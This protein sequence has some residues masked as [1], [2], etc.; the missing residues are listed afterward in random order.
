MAYRI[1]QSYWGE[2]VTQSP[3]QLGELTDELKNQL[4]KT[5]VSIADKLADLD[6]LV[7]RIQCDVDLLES[8]Q[9]RQCIDKLT[10]GVKYMSAACSKEMVNFTN[11]VI[12]K[13]VQIIGEPPC[14]FAAVG[15]GSLAKGET[16]PYSDLEFLFLIEDTTGLRYFERLALTIYFCIGNLQE[17]KLK[18]MNIKE[19]KNDWFADVST[20]G[21]KIDGLQPQA[22]N[23]PTGNGTAEQKNK[24][25]KTVDEMVEIYTQVF[26]NPDPEEAKRGDLSAMLSSTVLLYGDHDLYDDFVRRIHSIAPSEARQEASKAMLKNDMKRYDYLPDETMMQIK[27][28]KKD[29]YRFPSILVFDLKISHGIVHPTSWE[30]LETLKDRGFVSSFAYHSLMTLLSISI[31]SRLSAYAYH[32]SQNDGMSVLQQTDGGASSNH[33]W[34]FPRALLLYYFVYCIPIKFQWRGLEALTEPD[35]RVM[36]FSYI[37]TLHHSGDYTAVLECMENLERVSELSSLSQYHL[38]RIDSLIKTGR[39]AEAGK[40]IDETLGHVA[41]SEKATLV[42]LHQFRGILFEEENK[43]KAALECQKRALAL[44]LQIHNPGCDLAHIDSDLY[45]VRDSLPSGDESSL[46]ESHQADHSQGQLTSTAGLS[47]LDIAASYSD[48]GSIY[49]LMGEFSQALHYHQKSLVIQLDIAGPSSSDAATSY[50]NIAIIHQQK[51]D[52]QSAMDLYQKSLSTLLKVYGDT[53][54]PRISAL[55]NNIAGIYKSHGHY[56][57][58]LS[59]YQRSLNIRRIAYG[60][61]PHS[62]I[63]AS[64]NN[65]TDVYESQ[66]DYKSALEWNKKCLSMQIEIYGDSPHPAVAGAYGNIAN[67]YQSQGDHRAAMEY[68]QRGLTLLHKIH[69][70]SPNPQVASLYSNIANIH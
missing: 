11:A 64:Y 5:R 40:L 49:R 1:Q 27:D 46:E 53:P 12:A 4:K 23:I 16:T 43:Y 55:Y 39:H 50:N 45:P 21:F 32:S 3:E 20:S 42:A 48:I 9:S 8:D 35:S 36:K 52:Y 62:S 47:H 7:G 58:A 24:F 6:S 38:I 70:D 29:F 63:A 17:T 44:R 37:G 22:G 60:N 65:I 61:G 2:G 31:Y 51:G 56:S 57:L 68:S 18:Y 13:S 14:S 34:S 19:L 25:I 10:E 30:V 41:E 15:I 69:G 59:F 28:L 54:H 66:A 33:L 26:L 67:I